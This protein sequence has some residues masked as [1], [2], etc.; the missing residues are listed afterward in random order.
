MPF[1]FIPIF[2]NQKQLKS[3]S[4]WKWRWRRRKRKEC[5]SRSRR[6]PCQLAI[7]F[8]LQ[9]SSIFFLLH[10]TLSL[11]IRFTAGISLL[12]LF[13]DLMFCLLIMYLIFYFFFHFVSIEN[14]SCAVY[15]D[16]SAKVCFAI[17]IMLLCRECR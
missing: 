10:C 9:F 8:N 6:N 4:D 5:Y 13:Y 1:N 12:S 16:I 15:I 7:Q 14:V 2:I 11:S 17:I 3:V